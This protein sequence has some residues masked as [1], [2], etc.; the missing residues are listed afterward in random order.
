MTRRRIIFRN[1]T[2][3]PAAAPARLVLLVKSIMPAPIV[4]LEDDSDRPEFKLP[5]T[6]SQ[7]DRL[8]EALALIGTGDGPEAHDARESLARASVAQL[9]GKP[10]PPDLCHVV[11]AASGE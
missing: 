9:C 5:M 4:R 8:V 6:N 7:Y 1:K 11:V 10:C 2:T 3:V